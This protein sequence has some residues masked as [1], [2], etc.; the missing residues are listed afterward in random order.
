MPL[1]VNR[2]ILNITNT[3]QYVT[4]QS[5][6]LL[7]RSELVTSIDLVDAPSYQNY[8]VAKNTLPALIKY[9]KGKAP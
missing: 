5:T 7:G 9:F 6:S 3:A 8:K 4:L 2:S 1:D